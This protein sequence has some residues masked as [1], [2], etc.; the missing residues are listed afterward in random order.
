MQTQLPSCGAAVAFPEQ[1]CLRALDAPVRADSTP[2]LQPLGLVFSLSFLPSLRLA[3]YIQNLWGAEQNWR[4]SPAQQGRR[5]PCSGGQE[6]R[7]QPTQA[8]GGGE[9]MLE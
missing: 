3:A 8:E 6:V 5:E 1:C 2:P 9:C 7:G 4:R